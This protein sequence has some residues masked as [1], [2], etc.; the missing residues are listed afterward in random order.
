MPC[1]SLRKDVERDPSCATGLVLASSPRLHHHHLASA[2]F[3]ATCQVITHLSQCQ[4]MATMSMLPNVT[5]VEDEALTLATLLATYHASILQYWATSHDILPADIA[6]KYQV[7]HHNSLLSVIGD[8]F[9]KLQGLRY[10]APHVPRGC[11]PLKE[12]LFFQIWMESDS[13]SA[14]FMST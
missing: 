11:K 3:E 14:Q 10:L 4:L 1:P 5:R 12:L 8:V 7:Q 13:T 6:L 9:A 2:N